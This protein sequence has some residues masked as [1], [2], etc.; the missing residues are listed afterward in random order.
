MMSENEINLVKIVTFAWLLFWAFLSA[1]NIIFKRYYSAYLVIIIS[2]LF[3]GV[4]LLLDVVIGEPKYSFFAGLDNLRV[5]VRDETTLLVYCLYIAIVPVILWYNGIPKDKENHGRLLVNNQTFLV[6][7][8]GFGNRYKLGKQFKLLI[9]LIGYFILFLPIILWAF[10]PNPGVYST[11]GVKGVSM[12]SEAEDKFHDFIHLSS[13]LS[14]GGLI[15]IIALQKNKN[16]SLMNLYFWAS[17]L[18]P[19]FISVWLNGKRYIIAF[20]IFA[21]ILILLLKKAFSRVKILVFFLGLLLAFGIF[22]Y[23]YQTSLVRSV[24]T[25]QVYEISRFDYSRDPMLKLSIYSELNPD[26]LKILDHRLQTVYHALILH[27][28]RFLWP[29]KPLPYDYQVYI[30]AASFNISP[31]DINI[32]SFALT[33]TWIAESLSN[34]GWVGAFIGPMT[35]ALVCRFGDST[36][37]NF[38]IIFT[39]F[40]ALNLISLSLGYTV[41]FLIIWLIFLTREYYTKK[42]KKYKGHKI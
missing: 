25:K 38:L 7:L 23:S 19:T 15:T 36:R 5:A 3:F 33:G 10:S 40:L 41:L 39:S 2:F 1:K 14:L 35:L 16:L 11:Y 22:S 9:I 32:R 21:L 13:V 4:P 17:V 30:T 18:I 31:K 27:I 37:N 6:N 34:F 12:L 26:K 29:G 28:P 42:Y 20:V 8:A 24:A